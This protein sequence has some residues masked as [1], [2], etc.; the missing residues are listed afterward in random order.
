MSN[1]W[2]AAA[3]SVH[4]FYSLW[5]YVMLKYNTTNSYITNKNMYWCY[6]NCFIRSFKRAK[7]YWWKTIVRVVPNHPTS[8]NSPQS[9]VVVYSILSPLTG[10]LSI[11]SSD[12]IGSYEVP[13]ATFLIYH[14]FF[15]WHQ[16][17]SLFFKGS[18]DLFDFKSFSINSIFHSILITFLNPNG[19]EN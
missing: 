5:L 1:S 8:S 13:L 3:C 4:S 2:D 10:L 14:V 18:Q 15:P 9:T 16:Y 17:F 6:I 12:G 7:L 19:I 11:R